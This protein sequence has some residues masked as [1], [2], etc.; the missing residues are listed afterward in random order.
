MSD[1][2]PARNPLNWSRVKAAIL[3]RHEP[4]CV[5]R[6]CRYHDGAAGRHGVTVSAMVSVSADT[7]QPTLLVCIHHRS[8]VAPRCSRT[9]S[10]ASMCCA[11]TKRISPIILPAE[12]CSR[13]REVRLYRVDHP[14]DGCAARTRFLGASTAASPQANASDRICGF[15]L[16]SGYPRCRRRA[17]LIYANPP[18]ACRGVFIKPQGRSA[19]ANLAL[20]LG[21][22]Q[23]F[24]PFVVPRWSAATKL[25][26][27]SPDAARVRS[28][29][30]DCESAPQ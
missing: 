26:P 19:A 2:K 17:P 10:S 1:K 22:Y 11:T 8:A 28:T 20:T 24:A 15:R 13:R 3:A 12:R 9:A 14:G 30:P 16:R 25:H 21:C 5:Y 4:R 23:V 27:V 7:P 6:E 18:T 29:A